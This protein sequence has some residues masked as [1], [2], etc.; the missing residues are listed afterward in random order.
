MTVNPESEPLPP[1]IIIK[2]LKKALVHGGETH[3]WADIKTGLYEGIYQIFWNEGA[4]V[5]TEIVQAP[6]KKYLN[7]FLAAGRLND[8]IRLQYKV[9]EFA[10]EIGCDFIR[11]VARYGWKKVES[12]MGCKSGHVIY[13][14]N[15]K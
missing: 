15:L 11:A 13:T 8:V 6:R 4:A 5:V 9:V 10:N 12:D 7:V 1:E 2:R 3:E 14:R